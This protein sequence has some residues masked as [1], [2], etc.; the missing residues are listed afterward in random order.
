M[1]YWCNQSTIMEDTPIGLLPL[2][3]LLIF[4]SIGFI[5]VSI[6]FQ[7]TNRNENTDKSIKQI[8][9]DQV[10]A[11]FLLFFKWS[12]ISTF[13]IIFSATMFY[14]K[15]NL[16]GWISKLFVILVLILNITKLYYDISYKF[17][18]ISNYEEIE[19]S[20]DYKIKEIETS[21]DYK[22]KEMAPP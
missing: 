17:N 21:L 6:R 20:L 10:A 16:L 13:I 8:Y 4:A 22:I 11:S 14:L 9:N 15:L 12:V 5:A 18:E 1:I 2:S 3:S 19:T 7:L